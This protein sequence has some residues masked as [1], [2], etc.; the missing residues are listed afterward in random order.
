MSRSC[1]TI[2]TIQR[3]N[4]SAYKY[5]QRCDSFRLE[6]GQLIIVNGHE[7]RMN[8][9]VHTYIYEKNQFKNNESYNC[10]VIA[11][12][13]LRFSAHSCKRKKSICVSIIR[14]RERTFWTHRLGFQLRNI[15]IWTTFEQFF[16]L[17]SRIV[18]RNKSLYFFYIYFHSLRTSFFSSVRVLK[19]YPCCI[20]D[21]LW[22]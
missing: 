15:I 6:V 8:T 12:R 14:E 11:K 21:S 7:N 4:K 10:C 16:T 22:Q 9:S 5:I 18:R 19:L 1:R 2:D 3:T 20:S 17:L 13:S